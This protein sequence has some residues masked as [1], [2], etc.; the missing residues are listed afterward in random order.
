MKVS[1]RGVRGSIAVPGPNTVKYGGN[2]TCIQIETAQG[3]HIILDAGTGIRLV[4]EQ[5]IK[6]QPVKC[7]IFITHTHWDHIQG[8]PFFL[9]F[10]FAENKI[11]IY[12]TFDPIY[13]KNIRDILSQQMEYCYF[14]LREND[15]KSENNYHNVREMVEINVGDASV[16]SFLMNHPVLNHGYLIR[17]KDKSL[18]FSGD[19]EPQFNYYD[20]GED[21]FEEFQANIDEQ[22]QHLIDFIQGVDLYIADAQ[23]TELEYP[24]KRGWGH[25][26]YRKIIELAK[27]ANVGK[28]FLTHHDPN[29]TDADLDRIYQNLIDDT[30]LTGDLNIEIAKEGTTIQL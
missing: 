26:S 16:T 30:E 17:N 7:S 22:E 3:E 28:L 19:H 29:R 1:F 27:K 6:Q 2:T 9:P 23:Y 13:N 11:D 18:F 8:L 20:P 5:L 24:Q 4:G 25:G 12:G 14:P 15:L 10:F 21:G